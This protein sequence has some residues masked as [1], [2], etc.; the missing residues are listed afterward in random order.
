MPEDEA[1]FRGQ[2][3][4]HENERKVS[5]SLVDAVLGVCCT[6]CI[7]YSVY[8][9]FGVW[10]TQ[11]ILYSVNAMLGV[12]HVWCI[13]YSVYAVLGVCC[14]YCDLMIMIYRDKEE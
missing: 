7:L 6:S 10:C 13:L 5:K 11:C 2:L 9:V 12:W 1:T 3:V 14:T 8:A 4:I